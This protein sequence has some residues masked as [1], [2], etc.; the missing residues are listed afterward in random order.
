MREAGYSPRHGEAIDT[1]A[2]KLI[3]DTFSLFGKYFDERHKEVDTTL[4]YGARKRCGELPKSLFADDL[5]V[6]VEPKAFV[7]ETRLF[8]QSDYSVNKLS[9]LFEIDFDRFL[10]I[11]T[12]LQ[13]VVEQQELFLR[14]RWCLLE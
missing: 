6:P 11:L 1:P 2:A 3:E 13:H 7:C 14:L 5:N 10:E 8:N 4:D 12:S 9:T